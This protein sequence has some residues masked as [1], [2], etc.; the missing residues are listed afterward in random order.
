MMHG[1]LNSLFQESISEFPAQS[2]KL[3]FLRAELARSFLERISSN[4]LSPPNSNLEYVPKKEL[5]HACMVVWKTG[6]ARAQSVA[7]I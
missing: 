6:C 4:F 2:C 7:G 1:Q 3:S 5:N